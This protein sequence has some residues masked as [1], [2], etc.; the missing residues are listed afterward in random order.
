MQFVQRVLSEALVE[1]GIEFAVGGKRD[2]LRVGILLKGV[3]N[4]V[5]K[6]KKFRWEHSHESWNSSYYVV[7]IQSVSAH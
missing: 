4:G 5:G 2:T 6:P 1:L 3:D 7:R